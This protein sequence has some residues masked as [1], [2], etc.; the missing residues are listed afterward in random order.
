M[1]DG[2]LRFLWAEIQSELRETERLARRFLDREA[3]DRLG[4]A[5]EQLEFMRAGQGNG[6]WGL[7]SEAPL[8]TKPSR[9]YEVQGRRGA[10][11]IQASIDSTWGITSEDKRVFRVTGNVSTR[12]RLLDAEDR[13]ELGR[14]RVELGAEYA[15]GSFFHTQIRGQKEDREP[16]WPHSVPVPRLPTPFVTIPAVV[17][18]VLGELFQTEWARHV[19]DARSRSLAALQRRHLQ[20]R[21]RWELDV[22]GGGGTLPWQALKT[23]LPHRDLFLP[24]AD[25]EV[26]AGG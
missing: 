25:R 26:F 11:Q 4:T 10:R 21:L 22:V 9:A 5:A 23:A 1:R 3:A 2:Q 19:D 6:A 14:W 20:H 7:P 8:T 15:P 13:S 12:I 18:F 17:V 24:D 16:P